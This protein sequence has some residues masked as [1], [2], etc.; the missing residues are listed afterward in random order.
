MSYIVGSYLIYIV[1]SVVLTVWVAH[2]LSRSGWVFLADV[3]E[4]NP[5]LAE[6]VNRLLVVAFYLINVGFILLA[7]RTTKDLVTFRAA[8]ELLSMKLGLVLLI[9]G[10]LHLG[11]MAILH[12]VRQSRQRAAMAPP[13]WMSPPNPWVP[14]TQ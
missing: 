11:N 4:G 9:L 5:D 13:M 1:V 8:I 2:A 7:L 10:V 3:F 12:G 6:A 14:P